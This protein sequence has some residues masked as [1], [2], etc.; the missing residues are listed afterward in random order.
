VVLVHLLLAIG[1]IV[2]ATVATGLLVAAGLLL[3]NRLESAV[4]RAGKRVP[5]H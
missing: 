3:M 5:Q 4:P 2:G 1:L